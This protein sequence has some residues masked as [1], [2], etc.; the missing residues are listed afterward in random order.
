MEYSSKIARLEEIVSCMEGQALPL[1]RMVELYEE[2]QKLISEC[3]AYLGAVSERIKKM[4]GDGSVSD[5]EG[6]E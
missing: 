1:E 5:L 3:R 6:Q 4:E 2:G